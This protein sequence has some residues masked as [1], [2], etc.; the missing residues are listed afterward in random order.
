MNRPD[1]SM[2]AT[3]TWRAVVVLLYQASDAGMRRAETDRATHSPALWADLIA[4]AAQQ[5][6]PSSQGES[7]DE[8]ELPEGLEERDFASLVVAATELTQSQHLE[9]FP[10]GASGLIGE[11]ARLADE[12]SP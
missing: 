3:Q 10:P 5:L 8:V 1:T 7:L 2:T 11:I 9:D 6:L 4:S 12:V